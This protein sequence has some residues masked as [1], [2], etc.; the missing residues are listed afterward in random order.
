[1]ATRVDIPKQIVKDAL[2]AAIASLKRSAAKQH[3]PLIT[4]LLE[5]D[6]ATLQIGVNTLQDVK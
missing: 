5:K 4:E 3:N 1:M 6:I 2:E